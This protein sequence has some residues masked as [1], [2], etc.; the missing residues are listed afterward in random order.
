M[1]NLLSTIL[2]LLTI[3]SGPAAFAGTKSAT[4]SITGR[5][6]A[7]PCTVDTNTVNQTVDLGKGYSYNMVSGTGSAWK[8]FQLTL[9]KCPNYWTNATVT[10]TGTAATDNG[11]FAN[12][13]SASGVVL[14]LSNQNHS[15]NY[16]NG[17]SMTIPVD[18]SRNVTFPLEARMYNPGGEVTGGDFNAAVQ[19][20][21]TYQ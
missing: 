20:D 21:F 16:G 15:I 17:D 13:G 1:K 4:I 18:A 11:Y 3:L 5:I 14:Q 6:T 8:S 10:F 12:S 7:S 2:C 19:V 9:S